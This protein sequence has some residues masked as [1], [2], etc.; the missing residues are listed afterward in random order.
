LNYVFVIKFGE[1]LESLAQAAKAHHLDA[2]IFQQQ[3]RLGLIITRMHFANEGKRVAL[4]TLRLKTIL[5]R[6]CSELWAS[7]LTR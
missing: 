6:D 5:L 1:I 3:I 2:T 7:C 4:A